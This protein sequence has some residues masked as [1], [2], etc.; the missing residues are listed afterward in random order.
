M[1]PRLT[2]EILYYGKE[3]ALPKQTPLKA[4][5]LSLI[6]E[7]GDLRYIKWG[8]REIVRRIY[9]A[10]RDRNWAT[11]APR[12]FN[13]QTEIREDS[14]RISF[15]VEH[16]Q[17]AIDFLWKGDINGDASGAITFQMA[18]VARSTFLR[19]RIGFCVLHPG[20]DCAGAH[21]RVEQVDGAVTSGQ[22]PRFISPQAPFKEMKA[23]AHEVAPDVWAELRFT[24]DAFEME[25][26]RNWL[27]A[28]FKTFCPPLGLPFP[29]EIV[30]GTKISQSVTLRL[31]G[32]PAVVPSS[33]HG[34]DI[35]FE[36]KP[37]G[38]LAMPKIGLGVA[39]H[40]RSLSP[41]EVERLKVLRLG[42]LRVDLKLW[43]TDCPM[44]LRRAAA[45]ASALG[46]GL[47]AAVFVTNNAEAELKGLVELLRS[48]QPRVCRWAVFHAAEKSTTEPWVRLAREHL[49]AFDPGAKIG[50][51]TN[52]NFTELN[53]GRP[54]LQGLDFV[55]YSINPQVHAFDNSSLVETLEGHVAGIESA[56]QFIGD[57][58]LAITPITLKPRFNP[59]ATGPEPEPR[60]GDLPAQ[61]DVR[62][63]SLF[64]AG[65]TLGSLK[66][67]SEGGVSSVTYYEATGW[68]GV[69]ETELGSPLP[70][71]FRSLPGSVFPLFHVLADVGEFAGGEV[72]VSRSSEPLKMVGLALRADRRR[73]VLLANLSAEPQAVILTECGTRAVV[74]HLNETNTEKA[75]QS[76]EEFRAEVGQAQETIHGRLRLHLL[77]F[78]LVRIDSE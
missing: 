54:P 50:T 33:T 78:A 47:E 12:L 1:T 13:P 23:I 2:K 61:V 58:A 68:R 9:V 44:T 71:Q 32:R 29:A 56:R 67:V 15:E 43:E 75:M 10:V 46:I 74:K 8:G 69:M 30:E 6:F 22:F 73:R 34:A 5:P 21:C 62:Q 76:P 3:E 77:P 4:G 11:I 53:R 24:G 18:G 65:W 37:S 25:D 36:V 70:G 45:E 52:A 31:Q 48:T 72:L 14:F 28:S 20:P 60:P 55:C 49:Q 63:M 26:Q 27:D 59:D 35:T 66:Q 16:K 17:G 38:A 19:N 41:R 64:G 39:S 40:G 7:A 42:H 57:R 51:G